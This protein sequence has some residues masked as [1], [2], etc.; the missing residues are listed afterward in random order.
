MSGPTSTLQINGS[1]TIQMPTYPPSAAQQVAQPIS[2]TIYCSA[3]DAQSPTLNADGIQS[4]PF[5]IG[6]TGCNYLYIKVQGGAPVDLYI[7]SVDGT[8][9]IIPVDDLIQLKMLTKPATSLSVARTPGIPAT[10]TYLI[11]QKA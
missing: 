3:Y 4:I 8:S 11:A 1:F 7:T 9:Q 6:M 5:P 2:E 10:L